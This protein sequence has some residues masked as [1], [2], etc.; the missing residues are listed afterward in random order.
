MRYQWDMN[1]WYGDM[2]GDILPYLIHNNSIF[3]QFH[4]H[5]WYSY[6]IDI[7]I[8]IDMLYL[9]HIR[10]M[11]LYIKLHP[12]CASFA[13]F[14]VLGSLCGKS[15]PCAGVW[16]FCIIMF[17][18]PFELSGQHAAPGRSMMVSANCGWGFVWISG[19]PK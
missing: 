15:W 19:T 13:Q 6:P 4:I 16:A 17:N 3:I 9:I 8:K 7:Y 5:N 10:I 11:Y 1:V 2:N 12:L 14:R 18:M